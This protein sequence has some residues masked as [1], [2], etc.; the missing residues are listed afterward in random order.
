MKTLGYFLVTVGM[1]LALG[2]I[3]AVFNFD[4]PSDMFSLAWWLIVGG[5]CLAFT[6]MGMDMMHVFKIAKSEPAYLF[7]SETNT[8]RGVEGEITRM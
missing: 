4:Q 8:V 6:G 3:V 2:G 1:V 7:Q 5:W